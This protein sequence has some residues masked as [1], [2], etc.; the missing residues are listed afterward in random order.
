MILLFSPLVLAANLVLLLRGEVVGDVKGLS[1][2]FWRLA[3]DHVGDSLASNVK[4]SL[5]VEVVCGKD[6][7]E[8]H[9][10]I[11]L[12]EFLVPLVNI[13]SFLAGVGVVFVGLGRIGTVMFAPLDDLLQNSFVDLKDILASIGGEVKSR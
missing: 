5:D 12:H 10:L 2:L 7:F 13:C 11:D 9:F 3:L 1:D 4:Q 8:E 6:D